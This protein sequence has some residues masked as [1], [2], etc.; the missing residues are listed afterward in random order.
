MND[1]SKPAQPP[2]LLCIPLRADKSVQQILIVDGDR[3]HLPLHG[4][5]KTQGFTADGRGGWIGAAKARNGLWGYVDGKG[6][7]VVEPQLQDA[8]AFSAEG[9]SRF[10]RDD[11]W[12]YMNLAGEVVIAP[13]FAEAHAM[14][15]GVA[16][17][18]VDKMQW[19]VID[20][21]GHFVSDT[22]F[23][24][25]AYFGDNGLACAVGHDK[26][27]KRRFGFVNRSGQWAI[28]PQFE[29]QGHF[30]VHDVAVVGAGGDDKTYGVINS[31]GEWVVE[32]TYYRLDD[33]DDN[34]YVWF[35]K[36][37]DSY[38]YS[39][40]SS[41]GYMDTSGRELFQ[42]SKHLGKR[43]ACGIA[44][45]NYNGDRY[46]RIDGT[47]L[48]TPSLAYGEDFRTTGEFAVARTS[49]RVDPSGRWGLLHT[50]GSFVAPPEDLVEP[51]TNEEDWIVP[52]Q[53]KTPLVPFI[54]RDG[55][56][57][58][59]IDRDAT[60]VYRA[61]Y[62][63]GRVTLR[64]E[65]SDHP[66]WQSTP[67]D[68]E[69]TAPARFFEKPAEEY[70][71]RIDSLQEV[72][73]L[74]QSM[75]QETEEKL[76]ALA[77][78]GAARD[79]EDEEGE[80]DDDDDD[81]ADSE[82]ED[83]RAT[84]VRRRI[85]RCYVDEEHNGTYDFLSVNQ[86][87]L[88]DAT[89]DQVLQL[90]GARFGA[91]DNDPED[92]APQ[93]YGS[94]LR[95]GWP[96][97]MGAALPGDSGALAESR[98]VWLSL[99]VHSDSGDGDM[100]HELWLQTA[101][102]MDALR[103]AQAARGDGDHVADEVDVDE[104]AEGIDDA[105]ADE[106]S[107]LSPDNLPTTREGWY[108]AVATG[109][110]YLGAVPEQWLDDE[111]VDHAVNAHVSEL[112]WAPAR[113][114][115]PER[116]ERLIRRSAEDAAQIPVICMTAEGLQLARSLYADD[117]S[118]DRADK[119]HGKLPTKWNYESLRS[120]WG[121]LLEEER[122][123]QALRNHA[124][125]GDVPLWLRT[126]A[127]QKTAI[128]ANAQNI[129]YASPQLVTPQL[130]S[131]AVRS[132]LSL[133]HVPK[134]HV[135]P[136]LFA[137]A[138][139]REGNELAHVPLDQR[140]VELCKLALKGDRNAF[141]YVPDALKLE[142][143]TQLVDEDLAEASSEGEPREHSRWHELRAWSR[144]WAKEFEGAIADAYRALPH[145]SYAQN[146][147]YVLA[148]AYRAI[149]RDME[150]GVEA[151]SVLSLQSSYTPEWNGDEDTRWLRK[152]A[153]TVGANADEATL[154]AQARSRPLSLADMPRERITNVIVEAALDADADAIRYVPRRLMTPERYALAYK[155]GA[156]SLEQIPADMMSEDIYVEYVTDRGWRLKE[157]EPQLRTLRVC[158][159]AVHDRSSAIED[160]PEALRAQVQEEV[161]RLKA[162]EGGDEN[163]GDSGDSFSE[164]TRNA[165]AENFIN[166][167][168][169]SSSGK[170]EGLRG[171]ASFWA[172]VLDA[173]IF[174]KANDKP[175]TMNGFAGEL[176]QRPGMLLML[177]A[178][179]G[180]LALVLHAVVTV[181]VWR[182]EGVWWGLGTAILMGY[183]EVYWAW[184]F[185]FNAPISVGLGICCIVVIFYTFA[186]RF[187]FKRIL[188]T[189]AK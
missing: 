183:S 15:G 108:A 181:A 107:E 105:A 43:L 92:A 31:R 1:S 162:A 147:H 29:Y 49:E 101:P 37:R 73:P 36:E 146:M 113:F 54:A 55:A 165:L 126:D 2:R 186:W 98:Q 63:D 57:L 60:V 75:L 161:D 72:V 182:A 139:E 11:L 133:E 23:M 87:A 114:Q 56:Q 45:N 121:G 44:V 178:V 135:T 111:I 84:T 179:L 152:A 61:D 51:L 41:S 177:N 10:K 123:K 134:A 129:Q 68:G 137:E 71:Q 65:G 13:Q 184:K 150:A 47:E 69:C 173:L 157:L 46:I 185:L 131:K 14:N 175:K 95:P 156:K 172:F 50:D 91:P 189:F 169:N 24:H 3:I 176:E 143:T 62:G 99:Y 174:G 159:A 70:F 85:M 140:S 144:L 39:S 120:V 59:W 53:P 115:T 136:E 153:R 154:I 171:K 76:R 167:I 125:L 21:S 89:R 149:G 164:R 119:E 128:K 117:W 142:V 34:G 40:S 116:L 163:D 141:F 104:S 52:A 7:W 97:P 118:W 168:A 28:E 124:P 5:Q 187:Y 166:S 26:N 180:V 48:P 9:L 83:R 18:K 20:A 17:V 170:P 4:V 79:A 100:W 109:G 102:S 106:P 88:L 32:P 77:A 16:A 138:I 93:L 80:E 130:A 22:A 127:V 90:L 35:M 74:A 151:S 81:A 86:G 33:F 82:A 78:S 160:V 122:V 94:E 158:V 155:E 38:S 19:R 145:V 27:R 96:V 8:R 103:V 67:E 148:C 112:E 132:G 66:L 6:H 30:G 25:V 42:G 12:G 110:G 188:K 64:A 58:A